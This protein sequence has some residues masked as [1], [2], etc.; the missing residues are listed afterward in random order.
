MISFDMSYL[1]V[2]VEMA[3]CPNRCRH[4][5]LGSKRNRHMSVD[6][7]KSIATQFKGW[8]NENGISISELSFFSWW[9]EPDY[10]DDYRKL[11]GLEQELSS[12]GRAERFEL[13]ST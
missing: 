11:W 4:C 10:R 7:F 8:R 13:L 6:E 5:W 2:V 12:P 3:G 9:R 1:G